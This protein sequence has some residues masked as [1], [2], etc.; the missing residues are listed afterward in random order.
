MLNK[1]IGFSLQNRILVLVASVLLLIGGTYTA[2]HTEVDV[3]P[4]LNAPTVVIMTEANGMA[5]EEVEQLVTFPVET[6]VNGATGVRRVRSSS[7]NGFSV[8]WVEFDWDTDIYLARQIVS[9]KLAVVNESLPANVG[10]PTLGP[11]SSILG[12][13]LI[14]GLTADSTS[15]LDLRTIADWTIRPRLLSTGGVAQVAVLGGDIKEYQ[16]QLDPERM[17]HYGVTLSEV[18]NITREMNL[19]ANGGVLYEYGNEYIV[20]GVLSTDKV[21]Q[22]AKAV[23]RS[24]GVSG[25]P[26]LLEDIA[27]VQIGAKLPKLG[28]ASERGKHAVLLTVTKQPATSTLELTDKLEASLQDLQKNLPADVKVSTDIFRQ[29]RFIESSIGNVQKSLL[30]GGIFVVIVLFLF[31][32]NIRTTVIS[33]VTLPLS[34]IASILALH[35]MGFTINT[36][37]LGGMAIAIG[38]LVDDAIVDVENVYK[39]LHENRLKPAGEQLPILEVVFNAS[40]E[41]RM[42]ILNSTLIIIVSFVPLFF[43]SGMEGRMLVPLGIA[44]IVAL[45]ASTVVALTVTPVLCSYLLGKEKTKKQNNENSDS[46][47][48]RKM[49][50]WY[51][52]A[53]TFVLGHKKGVLGGTIGLFVVALGCF[54]TLGRSFLPPFN[55]GSFTINIS[56]LPGI[57]LE[58]SDKM[59]HRAEEL[60]LSIPEIQTVARKTGRAELDE[61]ALGVNV[62]EIEAPFELKDRSRSELV[63]EVREKLGTIVGANVEIG[64]PISHRI[65]AMLSGTKANI[66]IK[67]FGDDLNRMFTLGN[68]I[69]SAIQGI[70]GIADL[71]VEQQIERPQL[72]ISPKREMLAKY[73]ISLPEFSEFVN[74]CLAG[75]AVSQVYEKGKSFDL[76][77]RVKDNLRDEMEKIR[78]LMIDTGDGQ[79]I[80]LNYVAEIRSAMGPNTI[81]RENVKRKIVISANVADR[82]LRSVVN[83]IQAQ[84]DA[85]IKLP[86]G[87]HIEYGGQFESEQAASRT[88]ALT[89]FMSIVVIFLLLY[90]EFRS[91]KE[92]AI[93]LINLPLALIGGVFALLIT[94]GEVSIP[95]IIGFISLFGI[96]TR[97][98]MLLISHYNHLQQ[99]EGYGVYDSVI[100][101]SLDRLNPILM[102]ALSSALAL[103]PLALSGDLPGNEIQ[104]PM[105]KVILGGL[106]TSTFLNGFIIPIVYLMMHHNQQPKTSDNE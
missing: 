19:N 32:A 53:L 29:S 85:Q 64:Q 50:Q 34:L 20:R 98:G 31:L 79:K 94:T 23:V 6:A 73:G 54:F 52:S 68:E 70:P 4:D 88:L 100:R 77:V 93:I 99:E 11:Q 45:A 95:A 39:R 41:V 92:S 78:N 26:I 16:V 30:E 38:S 90:H 97:N 13:M 37:S 96:A 44:F 18:M 106:L 101:G 2:M 75:E 63:A 76:T 89:S 12:E 5:A 35:Y 61:H 65:D 10:K 67:L 22:I 27:D 55:E 81:S 87:Y 105:A 21:D 17:R 82:D 69:K 3:F 36:M 9:E 8:V 91:V 33:L 104:S 62:S 51:G 71:N 49:K 42:P 83:D 74:V 15:M 14:V 25:A 102:T 43:L 1:I 84:V 56:S 46:A 72:V 80:P 60:L 103:I 59:G 66:A 48:A 58:E 47:V 24:N 86:E 28:T 57:S 40:K 7:T